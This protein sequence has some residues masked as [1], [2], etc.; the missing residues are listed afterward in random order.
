MAKL[1]KNKTKVT[2]QKTLQKNGAISTF[3]IFHSDDHHPLLALARA[4]GAGENGKNGGKHFY[5]YIAANSLGFFFFCKLV[6]NVK[7]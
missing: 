5:L 4:K 3:I 2:G 7:Y 1:V 6:L